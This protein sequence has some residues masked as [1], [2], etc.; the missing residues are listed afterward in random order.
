MIKPIA[1]IGFYGSGKSLL[2]RRAAN[3]L[4]VPFSSLSA[5]IEKLSGMRVN[6]LYQKMGEAAFRKFESLALSSLAASGGVVATT[7]G[8]VMLPYNRRL[9]AESFFTFYLDAPFEVIAPHIKAAVYPTVGGLASGELQKLYDMR[10]PQYEEISDH[11]LDATL[12]LDKLSDSIINLALA[13][14]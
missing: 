13:E 4:G 1:I 11:T 9:L 12:P 10:K 14:V 6:T 2:G 8:C 5:E 3:E 7:G